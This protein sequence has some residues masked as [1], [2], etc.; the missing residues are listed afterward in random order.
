VDEEDQQR[1]EE[2]RRYLEKLG[3]EN[4]DIGDLRDPYD[5]L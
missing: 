2:D 5:K 4:Q 1:L 3:E